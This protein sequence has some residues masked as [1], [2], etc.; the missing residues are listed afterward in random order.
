MRQAVYY[1][2]KLENLETEK[3][4]IMGET[5]HIAGI[6]SDEGK[7]SLFGYYVLYMRFIVKGMSFIESYETPDNKI[8]DKIFFTI[9]SIL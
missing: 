7:M 2:N 9:T 1:T 8:L 4:E 6:I 3:T 5:K